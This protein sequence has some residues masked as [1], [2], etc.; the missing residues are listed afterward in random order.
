MFM[1]A[2]PCLLFAI[3]F[4]ANAAINY[5][6]DAAGRLT[7]VDYGNGS[8]ITYVYD[9]NGNLTMRSVQA[10]AAGPTITSVTTAN[11][12]SAIAQNTYVVITGSNLVPAN[13]PAAG[14]IWSNAPSFASGQLP[15]QLGAVSVT[16][17]SKPAFVYFYCSA[18]TSQVCT[19]DQ[20]NV[21]TPIDSTVGPVPVVVTSNATSSPPFTVNLKAV[22]PSFL[23]F[24][25]NY[26][27]AIH[28]DGS[29]LGPASLYPGLST[30]AKP[31]EAIVTYAVGFGLP[32]SPVANGSSTQSGSLPSLP[33][34]QIGGNA[35]PVAF[36]GLIGFPG[37]YQIN[38]TIPAGTPNGD[39]PISCTYGGSSTPAGDVIT[40]QQ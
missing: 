21:L 20:I 13:T 8:A 3:H 27:V 34:C 33:V 39:N 22:A 24:S 35:T 23:L 11:G 7:K 31:N 25:A 10:A 1:R 30:P 19:S 29:L 15:T 9:N 28:A 26:V 16:V 6:Y 2:L 40:V 37:L 14:L 36:A 32:S 38:L 5:T 12:G 4:A 18:A 17:N